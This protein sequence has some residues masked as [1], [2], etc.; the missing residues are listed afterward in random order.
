MCFSNGKQAPDDAKQHKKSIG[1]EVKLKIRCPRLDQDFS[2]LDLVSLGDYLQ[3]CFRARPVHEELV[4]VYRDLPT[5]FRTVARWN[6]HFSGGRESVKD[7]AR[8]GRPRTS[9]TDSSVERA[10]VLIVEDSN[11]NTQIL[12]F[13]AWCKLR[14]CTCYRP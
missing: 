13:G 4:T 12:S 14:K 2:S 10:E 8:A 9:V 3:Y 6:Q 5:S 7:E 11:Y 1:P